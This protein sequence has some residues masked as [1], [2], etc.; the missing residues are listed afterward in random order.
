MRSLRCE[1]A[2]AVRLL[3]CENGFAC[4]TDFINVAGGILR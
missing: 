4:E 1:I 3:R 2:Y